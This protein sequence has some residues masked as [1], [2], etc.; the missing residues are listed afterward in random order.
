M[1]GEIP[2]PG[3]PAIPALHHCAECGKP[4]PDDELV[5]Y[6]T[7]FVCAGCKEGFFQKLRE[8]ARLPGLIEYGGFWLRVGAKV[9]DSMILGAVMVVIEIILFAIMGGAFFAFNFKETNDPRFIATAATL[10]GL[11]FILVFGVQ[12]FYHVWFVKKYGGT[13]GKLALQLRIIA[14]DGNPLTWGR[15]FGRFGAEIF[16][17]G[18]TCN[19]GYI[20]AG[21]DEEKRTLHDHICNTRVVKK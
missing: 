11:L 5:G 2:P 7:A 16:I 21:F 8:G 12:C 4:F 13:P 20:I 6:L 9:I 17:T 10:Y 3:A 19:I 14:A 15:A 18:L 1:A